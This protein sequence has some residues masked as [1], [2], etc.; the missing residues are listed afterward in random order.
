[1]HLTESCT[2]GLQELTTAKAYRFS[3]SPVT[4]SQVSLQV[5]LL[6]VLLL[7]KVSVQFQHEQRH[8][9]YA[10]THFELKW[11]MIPLCFI[12]LIHS[13]AQHGVHTSVPA[14]SWPH[15]APYTECSASAGGAL[16]SSAK[17][18][19]NGSGG[20]LLAAMWQNSV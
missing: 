11:T 9:R 6:M 10:P 16:R 1:V 3:F 18:S 13:P 4:V 15:A 19:L 7:S 17:L 20:A 12:F 2:R 5:T 14:M 8:S